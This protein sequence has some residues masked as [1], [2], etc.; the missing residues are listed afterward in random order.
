MF[1]PDTGAPRSNYPRMHTKAKETEYLVGA[2]LWTWR[3]FCAESN[4]D[5]SVAAVLECL[6]RILS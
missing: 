6:G 1:L 5:A 4:R 2:V 3:Q